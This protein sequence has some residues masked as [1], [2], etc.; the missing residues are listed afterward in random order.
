MTIAVNTVFANSNNMNDQKQKQQT[1]RNIPELTFKAIIFG[2][3]LAMLLCASNIYVALKVGRTIA[4][5]IPA[6]VLSILFLSM[7]KKTTILEHNIVQTTA[8]AGDVVSGGVTFTIPAMVFM[9]LWDHFHYFETFSI[10]IIGGFLGIAF[11]VPLRRSMIIQQKLPYPEGIAAA[12]VL[13]SSETKGAGNLLISGG[14]IAA[15]YSF[16]QDGAKWLTSEINFWGRIGKVPLGGS[17]DFSPV[18]IGAGYIVGI[19]I[20]AAMIVGTIITWGI[21]IPAYIMINGLPEAAAAAESAKDAAFLVWKHKLKFMGIG[22]MVVGGLWG[23]ISLAK[24]MREAI[25]SSMNALKGKGESFASLPTVERD[26]PM[27]YVALLTLILSVPVMILFYN[28]L[29]LPVQISFLHGII[30]TIAA[31]IFSLTIAFGCAAVGSYLTGIVGSTLL[32]ISGVT[33][34]GILLFGGFLHIAFAGQLDFSINSPHALSVAG[35]T[36]MFAA[37]VAM[38]SGVSG[39]NMQDLKAGALVG[40]TPWKQQVM[41]MLGVVGG[42]V[43]CA[44]VLETLFQAYGFGDVMPRADMDP[45]KTLNAPQAMM[46][47]TMAK[48]LFAGGIEWNMIFI[49]AAI[50]IGV[51]I[52]DRYLTSIGKPNRLPVLS[53]AFGMY[54]PAASILTFLVG[55]LASYF[56]ERVRNKQPQAEQTR[57]EQRGILFASGVIAGTA[58]IG[59]F[60]AFPLAQGYD[61]SNYLPTLNPTFV[62]VAGIGVFAWLLYIMFQ[63]GSK[64]N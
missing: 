54:M 43:V 16:L 7:W 8:S 44:P 19:R 50:G 30:V 4:A 33:I 6:A 56:A 37:I 57:N 9:G 27:K 22:A 51:I 63:K 1:K 26:I 14:L 36:I 59:L 28:M 29:V 52:V 58:L 31:A 47:A 38:A 15:A 3:I 35:A 42:A 13:K 60:I 10:A 32:P 18:L 17:L 2:L 41:L 40:A 46:M 39:D 53:V 24:T 48:G 34:S 62:S 11:S 55:G 21:G 25:Q 49:G 20:A 12:E 23:M 64:T 61:V 5:S 45:T